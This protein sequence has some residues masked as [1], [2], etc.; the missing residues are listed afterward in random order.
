MLRNGKMIGKWILCIWA[1]LAVFLTSY[2][3]GQKE[4]WLGYRSVRQAREI[5][6]ELGSQG[7]KLTTEKP[8][9]VELPK[10][11]STE[12]LFAKWLTPMTTSGYVWIALDRTGKKGP[13]DLLYIDSNVNGSLKDE[14]AITACQKE[15]NYTYFSPV[16]V[17]FQGEDGTIPYHLELSFNNYN[18]EN[19]AY[20]SAA[21]WYEGQITVDGVKYECML[22]DY[23]ANGSFNDKSLNQWESDRIRL[24]KGDNWDSVF[25]GNF[26]SISDKLY[27]P[28]IARDGAYIKLDEAA[29][30]KFGQFRIPGEIVEFAAGGENGSFTFHPTDGKGKLPVGKYRILNW[31]IEQKDDKGKNWRLEA[32]GYN[33]KNIFVI[34]EANELNLTIGRPIASRLYIQNNGKNHQLNHSLVGQLEEQIT[35]TC[36]KQRP[37]APKVRITNT[38]GSY[39]KTYSLEY[40]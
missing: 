9:G 17:V 16:A 15:Q 37:A 4:Q 35:A 8:Q 2:A 39:N 11:K 6:G 12:P 5:V 14:T 20:V 24:K 10:F 26:I 13:Y 25:V 27:R 7:L 34:A 29:D 32:R 22:I 28:E 40:G 23:N 3:V 1:V 33:D 36:N 21:C 19:R 30:A 38:D 31:A 18:K